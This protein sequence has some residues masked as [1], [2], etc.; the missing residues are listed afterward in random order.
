MSCGAETEANTLM[1]SLTAG[2]D[3]SV[4]AVDFDDPNFQIPEAVVG[5]DPEPLSNA[6]LTTGVLN[7]T[8]TFDVLMTGIRAHLQNEFEKG[9]ITGDQYA[10]ATIELTA[11][12]MGNAV[13]FLL[14]R[15]QAYWQS[16]K[17]QYDARIAQ[18]QVVP[19]RVQLEVAKAELQKHRYEALTHQANYAL[20]KLKLSTESVQFCIAE[21][22]LQNILPAQL[23]LLNEQREAARAQTLNTRSDGTTVIGLIGKQKDLYSQQITSYKR[24]AE[25]K[26]AKLFTDAWITQKTIDE[27]LLAP[28]GFI[29]S[30]LDQVLQTLKQNNQF[31]GAAHP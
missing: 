20:T 2:T 27:G 25:V 26:A 31:D 13:Q 21:F 28:N 4:P 22:N 23:N 17:A 9:R 8:G 11:G 14:G 6:D 16:K 5:V 15:D 18:V 24:D 1:T 3:F 19:A 29:N 7:G 30:S 10:K 12:A